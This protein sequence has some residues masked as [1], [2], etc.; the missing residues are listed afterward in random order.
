MRPITMSL[1]LA[2]GPGPRKIARAR[3]GEHHST[4]IEAR[5]YDHDE[6]CD[7]AGYDVYLEAVMPNGRLVQVACET[8][9]ST[10]SHTFGEALASMPGTVE[11]A[12]ISLKTH[13]EDGTQTLCATTEAFAIEVLPDAAKEG[14]GVAEAYADEIV[15]MLLLCKRRYEAAEAARQAD[16]EAAEAGREAQFDASKASCDAATARADA[17]ADKVDAALSGNLDPLFK[18]YLDALKDVDGGFVKWETYQSEKLVPDGQTVQVD[19]EHVLSVKDGGLCYA[20]LSDVPFPFLPNVWELEDLTIRCGEFTNA[21]AGWNTYEFPEPFE[22]PPA[23]ICQAEGYG[24]DVTGVEAGKFLYRLTATAGTSYGTETLYKRATPSTSY[25]YV[26]ALSV[27]SNSYTSPF[28]V[29]TSA[30]GGSGSVSAAAKVRW[31]AIEDG[32]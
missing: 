10:A 29:L 25:P 18:D 24:V 6:P 23:V 11:L 22:A 7:L 31:I 2:K 3:Q 1:D 14:C 19:G 32:R 15:Q 26:M 27:S 12:Y 20:K 17:A 28:T 9:G 8:E 30:S 4:R 21:G 16:Y 13:A 5:I